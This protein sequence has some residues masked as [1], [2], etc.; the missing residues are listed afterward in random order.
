MEGLESQVAGMASKPPPDHCAEQVRSFLEGTESWLGGIGLGPPAELS[1]A[2]SALR[3]VVTPEVISSTEEA[4]PTDLDFTRPTE[5]AESD[6]GSV[7]G[8][9]R[10]RRRVAEAVSHTRAA[11]AGLLPAIVAV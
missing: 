11:A 1:A 8:S 3:G 7:D 4:T 10:V 6:A 5:P 9:R 2:A